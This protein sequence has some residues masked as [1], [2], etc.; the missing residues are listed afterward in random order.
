[1][2]NRGRR[3]PANDPYLCG[4]Y[5][6]AS[7]DHHRNR[8]GDLCAQ[9]VVTGTQA[10]RNH[11]GKS[12]TKAK[13]QG[14]VAIEVRRWG[15]GDT[16]VDPGEVLLRLVSQSA[17]RV[18]LYAGLLAQAYDAADRLRAAQGA[19]QSDLLAAETA[20]LDLERVFNT[21]GVSALIGHTYA[22]TQT[23]GVIA[24]GEA[25]RGLAKLEGEERDRCAN[26]AKIA[27]AAGL[28]ERQVRLAERQGAIM[29]GVIGAVLQQLGVD[30]GGDQVR[31]LVAAEISR[32]AGVAPAIEGRLAA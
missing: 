23:S 20:R 6:G 8:A 30:V 9:N 7:G 11:A 28:A 22:G 32:H 24:T 2:S 26:F 25:I 19:P 12:L 21:G 29:A 5:K 17:A 27:V 4:Y 13:A 18:E 14:A 16:T 10:C 1:M 3:D 15:L 31:A